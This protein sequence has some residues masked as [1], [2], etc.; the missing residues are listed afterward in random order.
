MMKIKHE[1]I[2]NFHPIFIAL[3]QPFE[4][5][6][7]FGSWPPAS[8]NCRRY[9][10]SEPEAAWTIIAYAPEEGCRMCGIALRC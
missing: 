1:V 10:L 3:D 5:I 4:V 2:L 9:P 8:P 7:D 6:L